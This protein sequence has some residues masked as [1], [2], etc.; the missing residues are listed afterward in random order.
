VQGVEAGSARSGSLLCLDAGA[1][2]I[3]AVKRHEDRDTL[4]VRLWNTG[5]LEDE[6]RLRFGTAIRG[7]WITNLLEERETELSS[8][9]PG[10]RHLDLRLGPHEI[11]TIE[12][13]F[14]SS[15]DASQS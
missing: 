5:A 2:R 4:V 11:L 3:S 6:Q 13:E 14:E 15:A 10:D 7:A 1:T 12:I 8:G 9:G